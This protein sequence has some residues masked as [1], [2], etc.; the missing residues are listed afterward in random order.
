MTLPREEHET[1]PKTLT[2]GHLINVDK[3]HNSHVQ[4]KNEFAFKLE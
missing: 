3:N 4:F 1:S 2:K